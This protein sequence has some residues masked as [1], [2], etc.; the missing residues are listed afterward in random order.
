MKRIIL[1]FLLLAMSL[2]MNATTYLFAT[3]D[4]ADPKSRCVV[5]YEFPTSL[6]WVHI[7]NLHAAAEIVLGDDADNYKRKAKKDLEANKKSEKL[8]A[9]LN[10]YNGCLY[11]SNRNNVRMVVSNG[12]RQLMF[13]GDDTVYYLKRIIQN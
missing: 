7:P 2:Q 10:N 13:V 8:F 5:V 9:L 11:Y 6:L 4:S 3:G 12:S 1:C